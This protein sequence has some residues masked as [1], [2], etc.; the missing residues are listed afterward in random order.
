MSTTSKRGGHGE[1][2]TTPESKD[3]ENA[4]RN[5]VLKIRCEISNN[6]IYITQDEKVTNAGK[7]YN[8]ENNKI[9]K[10]FKSSNESFENKFLK[11]LLKRPANLVTGQNLTKYIKDF[12]KPFEYKV[13]FVEKG[14]KESSLKYPNPNDYSA[15]QP[16]GG[17][18]CIKK[19]GILI[20]IVASETKYQGQKGNAIERFFD[21]NIWARDVNPNISYLTF[22]SGQGAQIKEVIHRTLFKRHHGEFGGFDRHYPGKNSCFM[23]VNGFSENFIYDILVKSIVERCEF[24]GL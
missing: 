3:I 21:N 9:F 12:K 16:D 23:S 4:L 8:A 18:F 6:F 7:I 20:P 1:V 14:G 17:F 24:Y 10:S 19:D 13:I 15:C 11:Y 2:A 22:A 5:A